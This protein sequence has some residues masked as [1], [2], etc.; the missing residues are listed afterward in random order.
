M[1]GLYLTHPKGL[2]EG[3][4][5]DIL[6]KGKISSGYSD[7]AIDTPKPICC[8][9]KFYKD[10]CDNWTD[11]PSVFDEYFKHPLLIAPINLI[12]W[13]DGDHI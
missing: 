9:E 6:Y 7:W 3:R 2:R 11:S 12:I 8:I 1:D 10:F 5:A 13:T 4:S